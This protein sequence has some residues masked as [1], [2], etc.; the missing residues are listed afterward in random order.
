MPTQKQ[1]ALSSTSEGRVAPSAVG[2]GSSQA[3][4]DRTEL[5]DNSRYGDLL[6][7]IRDLEKQSDTTLQ[8]IES[9]Y[10]IDML[11]RDQRI[12]AQPEEQF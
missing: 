7:R 5:E 8:R 6:Q 2:Q 12:S 1:E 11:V 4:L 10:Q 9:D 3:N